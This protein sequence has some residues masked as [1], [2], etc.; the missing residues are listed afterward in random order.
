MKVLPI[1]GI[2]CAGIL[3]VSSQMFFPFPLGLIF[4]LVVPIILI[5]ISIV[6]LAKDRVS[7]R[8]LGAKK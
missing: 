1:I 7:H 6:F 4:G 8:E 3:F 2:V 5:V